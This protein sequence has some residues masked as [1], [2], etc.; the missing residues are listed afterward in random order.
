MLDF[1]N[2]SLEVN[3]MIENS[4][5]NEEMQQIYWNHYQ[6]RLRGFVYKIS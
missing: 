1:S 4:F 3:M 6:N 2:K 5:L